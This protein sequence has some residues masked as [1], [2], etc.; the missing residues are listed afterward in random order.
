MREFEER[1]G[2][3]KIK[4]AGYSYRGWFDKRF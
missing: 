2:E 1:I 4:V 3:A